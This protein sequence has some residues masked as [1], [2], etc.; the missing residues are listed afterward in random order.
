MSHLL[1]TCLLPQELVYRIIF[2]GVGPALARSVCEEARAVVDKLVTQL[3]FEPSVP[4][5]LLQ[6][7]FTRCTPTKVDLC[8]VD[9]LDDDSLLTLLSTPSLESVEVS[10]CSKLTGAS[11]EQ[12]RRRQVKFVAHRCWRM[13]EPSEALT[14]REVVELQVLAL[15]DNSDEGIAKCF[16]FAS[17]EN[18]AQTGPADR[19]GQMIRG[20]YSVMLEAPSASILLDDDQAADDAT[21]TI[22]ALVIYH[23]SIGPPG[24]EPL[25][26]D[27]CG[28]EWRLSKQVSAD[29]AGC[30]M[31][32]MVMPVQLQPME[33]LKRVNQE[34]YTEIMSMRF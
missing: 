26:S 2:T 17:P 8:G 23:Q 21:K 12:L 32:D 13:W 9:S 3:K 19:F 30:W 25:F 10:G 4:K 15:R 16:S 14:T 20:G 28:F 5:W 7:R 6:L 31:T 22:C 18:K 29:C 24:S 11:L 33:Q 27:Q 34:T 1:S